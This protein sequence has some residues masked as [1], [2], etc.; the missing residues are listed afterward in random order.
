MPP[1]S[2]RAGDALDL[3]E[4]PARRVGQFALCRYAGTDLLPVAAQTLTGCFRTA[5]ASVW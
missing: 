2:S 4:W 3:V 1:R 5:S